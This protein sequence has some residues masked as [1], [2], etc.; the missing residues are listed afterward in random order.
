MYFVYLT[1]LGAGNYQYVFR[2]TN[3]YNRYNDFN[4]IDVY[5]QYRYSSLHFIHKYSQNPVNSG[6]LAKIPRY[7]ILKIPK[8]ENI[9]DYA[10]RIRFHYQFNS[11]LNHFNKSINHNLSFENRK[12][13][14]IA[15]LRNFDENRK[16]NGLNN[17]ASDVPSK[18]LCVI[19]RSVSQK[20]RTMFEELLIPSGKY[21]NDSNMGPDSNS[22]VAINGN[23]KSRTNNEMRKMDRNKM[24]VF[25][26]DVLEK[27]YSMEIDANSIEI[28]DA[29]DL[30]DHATESKAKE[31]LRTKRIFDNDRYEFCSIEEDLFNIDRIIEIGNIGENDRVNGVG[32]GGGL[33]SCTK[34]KGDVKNVSIEI[35]LKCGLKNFKKYPSM[36]EMNQINKRNV[37]YIMSN[38]TSKVRG[39]HE[40]HYDPCKFFEL[41]RESIREEMIKLMQIPQNNLRMFVNNYQIAPEELFGS[42]LKR[43]VRKGVE[44]DQASGIC[45][46]DEFS[47]R[48]A[49][50]E[51]GGDDLLELV[52]RSIVENRKKLV[53][54]S[55][56]QALAAGQQ[57]VA[58]A[59][60]SMYSLL[61]R[62]GEFTSGSRERNRGSTKGREIER[63]SVMGKGME[64]V[65][66]MHIKLTSVLNSERRCS[67]KTS[68]ANMA[69]HRAS[70]E[71]NANNHRLFKLLNEVV[72]CLLGSSP[73]GSG[74]KNGSDDEEN[75]PLKR[76]KMG[77]TARNSGIHLLIL[78]DEAIK[79]IMRTI[80]YRNKKERVERGRSI[81]RGI[82]S[83][84]EVERVRAW[85]SMY[86]YGRV[87][88]DLSIIVNILY[89]GR[90][91]EPG[92]YRMLYNKVS[93]VDL[94]LKSKDKI[95]KW[96]IGRQR[97]RQIRR[98]K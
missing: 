66:L 76:S 31:T 77:S 14:Y 37:N 10:S 38:G 48:R 83:E 95:Y 3:L 69:V 63:D 92:G 25:Y 86:L 71:F 54:V 87:A 12:G 1:P 72:A 34:D 59:L 61:L 51:E 39:K 60:Y 78:E 94:D 85:I 70:N 42:E 28:V 43:R 40:S 9:E 58:S 41:D 67:F 33:E 17:I 8:N 82:V 7:W 57:L 62:M 36:F 98:A 97:H 52:V 21:A 11:F 2:I 49:S 91:N 88:M 84:S 16:Q 19:E 89:S 56:L 55:K 30:I 80:Y 32:K 20:L 96:A 13:D 45:C 74:R 47:N 24:M 64:L 22:T 35:K 23:E 18:M 68:N 5:D 81:K 53:M 29:N 4:I 90:K 50:M 65:H 27:R 46:T 73:S 79:T 93:F 75:V 44:A 15:K 6:I 26:D